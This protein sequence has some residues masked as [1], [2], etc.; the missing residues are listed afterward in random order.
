MLQFFFLFQIWE[1]ITLGSWLLR[2]PGALFAGFMKWTTVQGF[3]KP[4]S[5]GSDQLNHAVAGSS[6]QLNLAAEK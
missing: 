2:Q 4:G 6:G 5:I 3:F 1:Q